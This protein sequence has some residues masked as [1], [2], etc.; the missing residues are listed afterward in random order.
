MRKLGVYFVLGL[1]VCAL[2]VLA[3]EAAKETETKAAEKPA[4]QPT[5]WWHWDTMTGDWGG[6]RKQLAD[7]GITFGL[8]VTQVIQDNAHGGAH[9]KN[10][11]RYSG[12]DDL[13][14]RLD[15]EKMGLWKGGGI[16]VHAENK[17]GNGVNAKVGSLLPVNFDAVLPGPQEC[18]MA[19]S[20]WYMTQV[21]LDGKLFLIAGKLW[22]ASAFEK[23]AFANNEHTQFLNTGFRNNPLIAP[24]LPYTD[25]GAGAI[26]SP[27]EWL[28]ILTAVADTEGKATT[29]GFNTTFHG[30]THTSII[31]EWDFKIKPFGK[32]GTQRVGFVW[33]S[34]EFP[35]LQPIFPFKQTGPLMMQL[36]GSKAFQKIG[37]MLPRETE[38]DNVMVYYN[39][40]QYVYTE[41]E[42]PTQGIGVFGRFGW[43]R[44]DVNPAAHF[45]SI[46][47]GG[48]GVLPE[49]DKDT[50]GVGYYYLD[51]SNDLPSMYHSEQGVECY[52]NIE[53]TPWL[54]VS[55]DVQLIMDPGGT[56]AY[57]TSLVWGLRMQMTL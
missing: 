21:L 26:I 44:Q 7:K 41:A 27:T 6:A 29:T 50:F 55:P 46:G 5:D 56:D 11:F 39:F 45:Y 35:Q 37:A 36:L 10:G 14:L 51:L 18:V 30:P 42:D 9:T 40:D 23:N 31:H 47:V 20:E 17:W 43:A 52:Y 49:R 1:A 13:Y 28:S 12:S 53:I 2:P 38:P 24:F 25:L 19:L 22:G 15:T 54:H 34:M 33:S 48:K 3:Q 32:P 57:E 4:A 16:T 8:D